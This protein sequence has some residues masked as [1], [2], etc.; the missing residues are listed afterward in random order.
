VLSLIQVFDKCV[1]GL[2]LE[3][4]WAAAF[5]R[6]KALLRVLTLQQ[7][8]DVLRYTSGGRGGGGGG[9][10]GGLL[11][12]DLSEDEIRGIMKQ[13]VDFPKEAVERI[14]LS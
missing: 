12:A 8:A 11:S 3:V 10:G 14:K 5:R 7:P 9:G 2:C 13:R 1:E 4:S 6:L